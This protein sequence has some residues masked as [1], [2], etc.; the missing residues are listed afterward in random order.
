[1]RTAQRGILIGI[2]FLLLLVWCTPCKADDTFEG[3]FRNAF[4]G[5]LVG[6]L[7]G[8]ALLVFTDKP[9][10]HL[11]YIGYG[12]AGGVLAGVAYGT[13]KT[14]QAL[15]EVENGK[16][17]LALPTIVPDYI[18]AGAKGEREVIL[19]AEVLRGRF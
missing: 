7:V 18:P 15:A 5:G 12:A 2:T 10:D 8:A 9:G 11:D 17:K 6:G 13:V 19:T 1:M 3:I 14:T 16:V 4:Y